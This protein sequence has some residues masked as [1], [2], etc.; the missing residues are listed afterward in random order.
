ME[1]YFK[2]LLYGKGVSAVPPNDYS[3]RFVNFIDEVILKKYDDV[4]PVVRF[5]L[6]Q[7]EKEEK[8]ERMGEKNKPEEN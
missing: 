5:Q 4:S 1:Y 7:K 2:S 8:A 6:P 3:E